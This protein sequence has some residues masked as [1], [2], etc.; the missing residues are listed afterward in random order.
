MK[1]ASRYST[2]D[3]YVRYY[4]NREDLGKRLTENDPFTSDAYGDNHKTAMCSCNCFC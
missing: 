3:F 4:S 2:N 1:I